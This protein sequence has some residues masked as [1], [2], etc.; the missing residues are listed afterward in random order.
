M[1]LILLGAL[2]YT[3]QLPFP[4]QLG[5]AVVCF[6]FLL[7]GRVLGGYWSALDYL[8]SP[9]YFVSLVKPSTEGLP[10]G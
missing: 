9:A 10:G 6:L 8:L 7:V 2:A 4:S 1:F 5:A 3:R